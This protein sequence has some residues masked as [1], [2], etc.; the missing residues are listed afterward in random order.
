MGVNNTFDGLYVNEYSM[1]IEWGIFGGLYV[2]RYNVI[3][4]YER[5]E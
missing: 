2:I 5:G 3:I 1:I 4:I